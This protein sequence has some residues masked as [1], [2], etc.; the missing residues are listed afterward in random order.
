MDPT[1]Q[2]AVLGFAGALVSSITIIVVA[3]INK[4]APAPPPKDDS[5]ETEKV[6]RERIAFL[7]SQKESLERSL[8]RKEGVIQR[9]K[10]EIEELEDDVERLKQEVAVERARNA[11]HG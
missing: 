11:G 4:P 3:K 7:E 6:L 1:V 8:D 10:D 5:A 2:V 9:Q